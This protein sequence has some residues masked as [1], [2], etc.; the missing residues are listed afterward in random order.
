MA[1]LGVHQYQAR[2]DD[3]YHAFLHCATVHCALKERRRLAPSTPA[4]PL[5]ACAV[6]D[7]LVC[8]A[9][10]FI[11]TAWWPAV[12]AWAP[13]TASFDCIQELLHTVPCTVLPPSHGLHNTVMQSFKGAA[14]Y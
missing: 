8:R 5:Q 3:Y 9:W 6:Q 14:V 10:W 12:F 11:I 4:K 13:P 1:Y 2:I 7:A